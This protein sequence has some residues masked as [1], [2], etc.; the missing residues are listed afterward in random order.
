MTTSKAFIVL[1][2]IRWALTVDRGGNLI[3]ESRKSFG[4]TLIWFFFRGLPKRGESKTVGYDLEQKVNSSVFLKVTGSSALDFWEPVP[5]NQ[6]QLSFIME[7]EYKKDWDCI[8]IKLQTVLRKNRSNDY[9]EGLICV[10]IQRTSNASL[11]SNWNFPVG[12]ADKKI[13]LPA[14]AKNQGNWLRLILIK[15]SFR[16]QNYL[17]A[18]V[19]Q[20]HWWK[21]KD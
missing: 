2:G 18:K 14:F 16:R 7:I 9:D 10:K 19:T 12:V 20:N 8:V 4:L 5:K 1:S 3:S 15:W 11:D 13:K 17:K 6:R 21:E